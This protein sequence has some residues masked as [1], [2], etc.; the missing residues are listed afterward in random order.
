MSNDQRKFVNHV[1]N[2]HCVLDFAF[3]LASG[4]GSFH[5]TKSVARKDQEK[6]S[7]LTSRSTNSSDG[8]VGVLFS[9]IR[10]AYSPP[11]S[12]PVSPAPES[13]TGVDARVGGASRRDDCNDSSANGHRRGRGRGLLH[14]GC[15]Q[16]FGVGALDL[17]LA[18]Q[19]GAVLRVLYKVPLCVGTCCSR[20][21]RSRLFG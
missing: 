9:S 6:T 10:R 3:L 18:E 11:V 14:P 1:S 19:C 17:C 13:V 20:L 4:A 16:G 12:A 2:Q 5:T 8:L 15:D 7:S 21:V